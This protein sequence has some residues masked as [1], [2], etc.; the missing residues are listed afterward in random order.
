MASVDKPDAEPTRLQLIVVLATVS[1]PQLSMPPPPS[2][3]VDGD[4]AAG[5]LTASRAGYNA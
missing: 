1:V 2:T 3:G 4:A 5:S